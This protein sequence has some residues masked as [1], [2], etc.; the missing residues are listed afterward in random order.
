MI[1]SYLGMSF[2]RQLNMER[3]VSSRLNP[4][5]V[6]QQALIMSAMNIFL[7]MFH[8][9]NVAIAIFAIFWFLPADLPSLSGRVVC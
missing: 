6:R 7:V 1:S 5:K 8:I 9:N 3:I 2:L 4:L